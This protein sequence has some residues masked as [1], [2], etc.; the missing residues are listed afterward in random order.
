MRTLAPI[1]VF[2]VGCDVSVKPTSSS[3]PSA[4]PAAPKQ[5]LREARQGFVTKIVRSGESAGPAETPPPESGFELIR[6]DSPAGSLAA[7]LTRDPGDG[8]KHPA[9]VWVTGGDTNS[10]GDV[11]S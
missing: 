6:Y 9:I 7:Y 4:S 8:R 3:S 11:W 2:L 10:I 1:L 5:T